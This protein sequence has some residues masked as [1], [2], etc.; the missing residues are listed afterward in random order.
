MAVYTCNWF[1][2]GEK[3]ILFSKDFVRRLRVIMSFFN[4]HFIIIILHL[5]FFFSF[6]FFFFFFLFFFFF[7]IFYVPF[8]IISAHMRLANQ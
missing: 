1:S 7:D 5:S 3:K 2:E 6:F 8:M 4:T